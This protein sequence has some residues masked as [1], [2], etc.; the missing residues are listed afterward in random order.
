METRVA[1]L[2]DQRSRL[3]SGNLLNRKRW[4]APFML[5]STQRIHHFALTAQAA[6]LYK[7]PVF[8]RAV[9]LDLFSFLI[10]PEPPEISGRDRRIYHKMALPLRSYCA[11]AVWCCAGGVRRLPGAVS[12]GAAPGFGGTNFGTADAG[13]SAAPQ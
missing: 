11:L 10:W 2:R 6:R 5:A 13:L 12:G 7:W 9:R 4:A 8:C 1:V 3:C